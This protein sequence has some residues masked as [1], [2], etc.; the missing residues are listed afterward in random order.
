[1]TKKDFSGLNSIGSS[2]K[3]VVPTKK[4]LKPTSV[5]IKNP[6]KSVS[7][8]KPGIKTETEEPK[9][10]RAKYGSNIL[11]GF[12]IKPEQKYSL[13]EYEYKLKK[14]FN[15]R[16]ATSVIVRSALDNILDELNSCTTKEDFN[17]VLHLKV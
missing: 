12:L 11:A 4:T 10:D 1:M 8:P 13:D 14:V 2:I 5:T 17:K 9:T 15:K 6:K 3:T 16:I 7:K